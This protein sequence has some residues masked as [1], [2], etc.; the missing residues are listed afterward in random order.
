MNEISRI[1]KELQIIVD[2]L[3]IRE[4]DL[5]VS[6]IKIS[7]TPEVTL[8]LRYEGPTGSSIIG[9]VIGQRKVYTYTYDF[10]DIDHVKRIGSEKI[11]LGAD[12]KAFEDVVF[13]LMKIFEEYSSITEVQDLFNLVKCSRPWSS[14]DNYVTFI[15][16]K[17]MSDEH[18][19]LAGVEMFYGNVGFKFGRV[20]NSWVDKYVVENMGDETESYKMNEVQK[21]LHESNP[22]EVVRSAEKLR[23]YLFVLDGINF[24][25]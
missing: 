1:K 22:K 13:R 5:S 9:G 19:P 7:D 4:L 12:Q 18:K 24:A 6:T 3:K 15:I 17:S 21:I 14:L 2:L 11:D 8:N 20:N 25:S 23:D 16:Y 10:C